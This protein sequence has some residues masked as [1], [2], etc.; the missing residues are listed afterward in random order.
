MVRGGASIGVTSVLGF[1]LTAYRGAI[2]HMHEIQAILHA[3]RNAE[4]TMSA[5]SGIRG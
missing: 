4:K 1:I 3:G 2:K 5:V